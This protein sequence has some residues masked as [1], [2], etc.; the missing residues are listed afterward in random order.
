LIDFGLVSGA[1]P[2]QPKS[3]TN[4]QNPPLGLAKFS[5]DIHGVSGFKVGDQFRVTGLPNKFGYPNFY[6][7]TKV[8]HAIDNMT[9]I[10]NIK[11]DMRL[12][13]EEED[14]E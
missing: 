13:G 11:G 6:Q 12:I 7:V 9:W 8:D 10:T 1:Q 3:K 5:F 2:S 4:K 14:D